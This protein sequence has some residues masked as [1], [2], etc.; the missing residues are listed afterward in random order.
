M[1]VWWLFYAVNGHSR[2]NDRVI[3]I[4]LPFIWPTF[5]PSSFSISL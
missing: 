5:A 1:Y 4:T 3:I 2:N